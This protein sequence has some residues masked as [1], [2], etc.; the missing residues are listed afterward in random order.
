MTTNSKVVWSEGLFLRPQ[1]FQQQERFLER[2]VEAR[3]AGL[4][5]NAWGVLE[6]EIE[7][8]LLAIG[9]LALRRVRGVF[10]DGT[11]FTMPE[12]DPL[13]MPFEV[14][15]DLR[16]EVIHLAIP[17]RRSGAVETDRAE[18]P[19]AL[20][21]H[22][23]RIENSRSVIAGEEGDAAIEVAPLRARIVPDSM[24]PEGY[25][26]IPIAHIT[27]RRAD[28]Q[29][30]LDD[31]FIPT[32]LVSSAAPRVSSFLTELQGMLHQRG[33]ALAQRAVA[34]GRAASAEIADFLLLQAVNRYEPLV[35]H[36]VASGA[37]HPEDAYVWLVQIAGEL[38]TLTTRTRR[39]APLQVYRHDNLRQCYE[40]V[41]AALRSVFSA[42][43]DASAV[44]IPVEAKKYGISV[45]VVADKS[46]FG[47]AEFVLAVRADIAAEDLRRLF[48]MQSKIGP[49]EKIGN[50][51]NLQLPGISLR[52]LPAAPRQIPYHAGF[53]YFSLDQSSELWSQARISGAVAFH[54]SGNFPGMSLEFW[55]IRG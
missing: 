42:T 31:R 2:Y 32:A 22:S 28:G 46:L 33:E 6:L 50:L 27:E 38:S 5:S 9:K 35:T 51:V 53:A 18:R 7:R 21:R 47:T 49:P 52:T 20:A 12:D 39:P 19:D 8:D 29:V 54:V 44:P 40:P 1:H 55:A 48:P 25:A 43:L 36:L 34:T 17:I 13:P 37:V 3:C 15:A 10:P 41:F 30:V 14:P 4:R 26:R 45:A 11:P 24:P 23:V 16:D